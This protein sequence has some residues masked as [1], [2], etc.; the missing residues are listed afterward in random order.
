[1]LKSRDEVLV[2]CMVA[3]FLDDQIIIRPI[4]GNGILYIPEDMISENLS[5]YARQK[6]AK[7]EV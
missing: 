5:E 7:N 1:M 3:G 2:H 6:E 4:K